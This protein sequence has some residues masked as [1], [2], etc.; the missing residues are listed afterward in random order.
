MP[1]NDL[2]L[3]TIEAIYGSGLDSGRWPEAL[4]ST[5]SLL[6]GVGT[7][8]E[9]IDPTQWH[10]LFCVV[11]A[12]T[13][14]DAP[15]IQRFAALASRTPSNRRLS[16]AFHRRAG[17]VAWDHQFSDEAGMARDPFYA[18]FLPQFGLRYFLGAVLEQNSERFAFVSVQRTRKQGHVDEQE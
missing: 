14:S 8:L 3:Q 18:E 13:G 10:S 12:V 11:G 7:F 5:T 1:D 15:S 6:G 4:K 2:F 9:V 16:S 17:Y